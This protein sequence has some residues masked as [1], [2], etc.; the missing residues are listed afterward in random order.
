MTIGIIGTGAL[1]IALANTLSSKNNILMWTKFEEE[2]SELCNTRENKRFLP[3]VKLASHVE[4]TTDISKLKNT[5][6]VVIA[7]PF[8]AV[9]YV[10]ENI[11]LWY[12]SQILISTVKGVED[13]TF[14]TTSQ[15]IEEY[16]EP[17][18][19]CVLSGPS[20]AVEI[21]NGHSIH[22]MLGSVGE[23]V[24]NIVMKLFEGSCIKAHET[25]DVVGVELCGAI[26]NAIAIGAGI[27]EGLNEA[28]STKAAYLA[29]GEKELAYILE[30]FGK[31]PGTAY[32]YAGIGDLI[33]TC[34]SSKSRNYTFGKLLGEGNTVEQA[35]N[36]IGAKTVEGYKIIRALQHY[37]NKDKCNSRLLNN[38]YEIVFLGKDVSDIIM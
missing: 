15:I 36:I 20:F 13:D 35:F 28:D 6:I 14:K 9:R 5:D 27:L 26:K 7:V 23:N 24:R 17:K 11:D 2:K 29:T 30:K 32:S 12:N 38:L 37:L 31:D 34:T 19:V 3:G 1:G 33:L 21:A 18:K 25:I 8:V 10:L 16:V 4:V 22:M